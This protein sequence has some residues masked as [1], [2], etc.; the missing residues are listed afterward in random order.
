MKPSLSHI[1]CC[2]KRDLHSVVDGDFIRMLQNIAMQCEGAAEL[3]HP[4]VLIIARVFSGIT[5]YVRW[6]ASEV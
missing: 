5:T 3:L 1:I 2:R 6:K 4:S